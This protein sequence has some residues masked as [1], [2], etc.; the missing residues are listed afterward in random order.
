MNKK[1]IMTV[2]IISI[3]SNTYILILNKQ[4]NQK[5]DLE[6]KNVNGAIISNKKEKEFYDVYLIKILEGKYKNKK[7]ILNIKNDNY[8]KIKEI[9]KIE[10]EYGN[11]INISKAEISN[12]KEQ[13]NYKGFSYKNYLKTQGIIG[14]I[15]IESS[16][17]KIIEKNTLN[18]ILKFANNIKLK[19]INKIEKILPENTQGILSGITIG[20]YSNLPEEQIENFRKSSLIHILVISGAHIGYL[21][22]GM[23]YINKIIKLNEKIFNIFIILILIFFLLI[24][25]LSPSIIRA[26][27]MGAVFL[28][29]KIIYSKSDNIN[30]IILSLLII[31]IINPF[32]ICDI[33]LQLSFFGTIGIIFLSK[34]IEEIIIKS[35]NNNNRIVKKIITISSVILAAQITIIPIILIHFNK[36][37]LTF[38]FTNFL[39]SIILNQIIFIGFL[40]IILPIF[41]I[42]KILYIILNFLLE[43][44]ILISEIGAKLP[45]SNITFTTP[46]IITIII[47]L[48]LLF[49][50]NLIY[51]TINKVIMYKNY[52]EKILISK[53]DENINIKNYIYIRRF[54]KNIYNL[55]FKLF[56]YIKNNKKEVF[57][58]IFICI[59]III[60][61]YNII[62]QLPKD[63]KIYFIDV[64]QG[65]STLI[66]TPKNKKILI[67]TGDGKTDL[68]LAYLL[69]RKIKKVDYIIISH[70]DKDHCGALENI[71]I[72]LKV[73]KIIIAKQ[74]KKVEEFTEIFNKI[75]ERNIK[76][77]MIK[78]GDRLNIEKEVYIDI[79]YPERSLKYE[80]LNNNSIVCKLYYGVFSI[81]F[82]GDI[83]TQAEEDI[84]KLNEKLSNLL[85]SDIL[86]ISHHGAKKS[87]SEEF[88]K[89]V[90]PKIALIGVGE[91]NF[92]HPSNE[93]LNI[94]Q[95]NK[96]KIYR[97]DLYGEISFKIN[98]KKSIVYEKIHI[99]D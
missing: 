7:F 32:S 3:I 62:K 87:T 40:S 36:L 47:Y 76:I 80:D 43:M 85:K 91:N 13:R 46:N 75:K 42:T 72:N 34:N 69:D 89:L 48:V 92:G 2:L 99:T 86:K 18:Y 9:N 5:L 61:I 17:I 31:L 63:L 44:L 52:N 41:F 16:N 59:L 65:D 24:I 6:I 39:V 53:K 95:N 12:P 77:T 38:L 82:T 8:S 45:F 78:K 4:Y 19:T 68:L 83:S 66:I 84:M 57:K 98:K 93:I 81:L 10:I 26:G 28:I 97:T 1:V 88:I 29:S 50:I 67:D 15:K 55:F 22:L 51:I 23:T 30:N 35:I 90:K 71:L 79:L 73:E 21:I 96:I 37:S 33:G 11:L 74:A 70:F 64:G 60:F 20:A 94:L 25:G 49:L 56:K 54:E 58:K 27:I 14:I